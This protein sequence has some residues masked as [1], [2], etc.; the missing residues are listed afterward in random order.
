MKSFI[1]FAII[2]CMLFSTGC[3]AKNTIPIGTSLPTISATEAPSETP[4]IAP[5]EAPTEGP[6]VPTTEPVPSVEAYFS[7]IDPVPVKEDEETW[8]YENTYVSGEVF[9]EG[10]NTLCTKDSDGKTTV[11]VTADTGEIKL[12]DCTI[13]GCYFFT[14]NVNESND[15]IY[16]LYLP[17]R[18]IDLLYDKLPAN[19]TAYSIT[20]VLSN[21][22]VV[23]RVASEFLNVCEE[24]WTKE[25]VIGGETVIPKDYFHSNA[26]VFRDA[27]LKG[28][29]WRAYR[30]AIDM[31]FFYPQD[32]YSVTETYINGLTGDIWNIY[33][34]MCDL[35]NDEYVYPDGSA[36]QVN[37]E[38]KSD[39]FWWVD[40]YYRIA[41][42]PVSA[43]KIDYGRSEIYTKEEMDAAIELIISQFATWEGC[44]LH[45]IAYKSDDVC[46][47]ANIAWMNQLALGKNMEVDFIEC[48]EFV[49]DFHSPKDGGF[50]WRPN[51][52]YTDWQWWLART[53]D[54]PWH[55]MTWGY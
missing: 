3:A 1:I 31:E 49:S 48:I 10:G 21:W 34:W 35:H 18:K 20:H 54:G 12:F 46:N 39:Y 30:N 6:T 27:A 19:S 53:E 55:L 32:E 44:E 38:Y 33:S 28:E 8:W 2:C 52:E 24:Q 26:D 41:G 51:E 50:E 43:L 29:A 22:E 14:S 17:T 5:T 13:G 25:T 40:D 9:V 11:I 4:T 36:R 37:C 15:G 47:S 45:R 7:E 42:N 23:V 16:R